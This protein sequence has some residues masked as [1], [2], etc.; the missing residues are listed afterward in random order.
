MLLLLLL[1]NVEKWSVQRGGNVL[2]TVI[3]N[4][5][6]LLFDGRKYR[7]RGVGVLGVLFASSDSGRG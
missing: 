7:W 3:K 1:K 4:G 2:L 6:R 5:A